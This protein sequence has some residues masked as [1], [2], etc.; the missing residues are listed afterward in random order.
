[1]NGYPFPYF[2]VSKYMLIKV[3]IIKKLFR[4][5][6]KRLIIKIRF[7]CMMIIRLRLICLCLLI[8]RIRI[9]LWICWRIMVFWLGLWMFRVRIYFI[10]LLFIKERRLFLMDWRKKLIIIC[11]ITLV[12]LR[13]IMLLEMLK[14][15]LY[16]L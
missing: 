13:Y 15:S 16:K 10:L 12:I 4:Y 7:I 9:R 2:L 1:M 5:F 14:S 3:R 6:W 8:W 11:R